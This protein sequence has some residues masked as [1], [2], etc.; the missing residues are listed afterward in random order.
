MPAAYLPDALNVIDR[1]HRA[2]NKHDLDGL[3][4]CFHPNY[5]SLQPLHPDHNYQGSTLVRLSWDH[6]FR[7][8]PDLRAELVRCAIDGDM[9]WTERKPI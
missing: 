6:V 7:A 4:A 2:W 1:L 9:A 5:A 8:V 3:A